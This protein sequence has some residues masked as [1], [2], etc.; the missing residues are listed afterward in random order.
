MPL[1]CLETAEAGTP[2]L[3]HVRYFHRLDQRNNLNSDTKISS[4]DL[5]PKKAEYEL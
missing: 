3:M 4:S 1:T 5:H 2:F